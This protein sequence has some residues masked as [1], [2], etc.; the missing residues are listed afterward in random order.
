MRSSAA[1]S[2]LHFYT[3]AEC[4]L[5]FINNVYIS[6]LLFKRNKA[7][8]NWALIYSHTALEAPFKFNILYIFIVLRPDHCTKYVSC[9]LALSGL[10]WT[11][12]ERD[13]HSRS[14][15]EFLRGRIRKISTLSHPICFYLVLF[16]W[17]GGGTFTCL[18]FLYVTG[19]LGGSRR[20]AIVALTDFMSSTLPL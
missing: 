13:L 14:S 18:F 7:V 16:F 3:V 12:S 6:R 17:P 2:K 20:N 1:P 5:L 19:V 4:H 11:V 9:R 10:V 8:N 15:S